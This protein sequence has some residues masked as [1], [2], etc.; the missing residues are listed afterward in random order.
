M[1]IHR[2]AHCTPVSIFGYSML[3][4]LQAVHA[5]EVPKLFNNIALN[6]PGSWDGG[7]VPGT[8]DVAL[9]NDLFVSTVTT[10][11]ALS[12]MGADLSLLGIKVT[13]VGGTRNVATNFVGFQNPS[14]TNT[15]TLGAGG[16]DCSTATQTFY[17]SPKVTIGADQTWNIGNANTNTNPASFNNN[18]DLVFHAQA[19]AT[20]FNLG[21]KTVTTTGAG[22]ITIGSG[23]TVSNGTFAVGNNLLVIAGGSNRVTTLNPDLNLVVNSGILRL[24]S[25]S[26]AGGVSFVSAA[27]VTVNAARLEFLNNNGSFSLAQSGGITLNQGSTLSFIPS[28]GPGSISGPISVLGAT[29]LLTSGAGSPAAAIPFSGNL[30]GSGAINHAN[31]AT[32]TNGHIVLSGDNS[33]YSG[34]LTLN[35][36]SGNRRLLLSTATSGSAAAT[37][38]IGADNV[39]Q[40]NGVSIQLGTLSGGGTVTNSSAAAATTLNVSAGSFSGIISDGATQLT[41]LTKIGTGLLKLSGPNTYSGPTNVTSGQLVVSTS[42]AAVTPADFTVADAAILSVA[43]NEA[44]STLLTHNLTLGSTA[45]STLEISLG[46]HSNPTFPTVAATSLLVNGASK[47]RISGTNLVTGN[48]P[49]VQYESL[50]GASGF[51]GLSLELPARTLG[52]LTNAG[53]ILGVKIDSVEQVKW[54]GNIS[55]DWDIDPD[56]SQTSGTANWKTTVTNI[57]TRYRQ[58][59][60]GTDVVTFDDTASGTGTVN[61]TTTL[62]PAGLTVNN[63]NK[64]YT[65]SGTGKISGSTG[66][67]KSG[68]GTLTLA[69]TT[70]NDYLGTTTVLGGTLRLGDGI[71]AGAGAITG[72]IVNEG[73]LVLDRPDDFTF[74]H[75]LSGVG[76]LEKAGTNTVTFGTFTFANP[77][78]VTGGKALFNNGGTLSGIL[79]GTG[80]LEAAGGTLSIEGSE[81]NTNT[82]LVTVS[83]GALRLNKPAGIAAVGGDVTIRGGGT[84]AIIGNEQIPD[85]ATLNVLGTSADSLVNSVGTETIANANLSGAVPETQLILRNFAVITGTATI[86]QGILGVASANTATVNG[87]VMN[88]ATSILRISGNTA[89]STLNLG[90]GGLTASAGEVQIKF[91]ANDQDAVLNLG[92]DVTTTGNLSFTNGGYGGASLNVINLL[93][94]VHTFS[95]GGATTTTVA[96]DFGGEGS[97][98]KSGTG[99]LSLGASSAAAHT[100]GT[101]VNAGSLIANG[102]LGGATS[103]AA[104]GTIGGSGTLAGSTTVQGTVAPGVTTGKLTTT[105]PITLAGGSNYA[106]DIASWTGTIPGTDWDLLAADTLTLAATPASK[107]TIRIAGS[108]AGFTETAKTLTIATSVNPLTGFDA[109]AIAIDSTGFTGSGT[110][111]VQQT[112]NT[113]E[114]VYSSGSGSPYSNWASLKGLTGANSAPGLDPDLD[115]AANFLE[116]AL[117][118]DP[119]SGK[120]DGKVASKVATVGNEQ[121]LTLTIPVRSIAAFGGATEKTLTVDNLVYRIQGSDTLGSWDLIITEI[122]GADAAAIQQNLPQLDGGWFYHSFRS[123]GPVVGDPSE[124]LRARVDSTN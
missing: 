20:P 98:V 90:S 72:S 104:T 68:T 62:S 110:W 16:I 96:P 102:I 36:A 7:V 45:G 79:S 44:D 18:E 106:F 42:Q 60:G 9:W 64:A 105:A 3:L 74:T 119:L 53:G 115:G 118:G 77:L 38:N 65:F 55:N 8:A 63:T 6:L 11:G 117:N 123:P 28:G 91:N 84:V 10:T 76:G 113:L 59:T 54:V 32:G 121:A 27:P 14:S 99:T 41:G 80:Q 82:G 17:A 48:F 86:T 58:G 87:V 93:T 61:L 51:T 29:T 25:N 103:V 120:S 15:L 47:I 33:G 94:G 19:A 50:G 5:A 107:L 21:G 85:T 22:Q 101:T 56:G 12:T 4:C 108:P 114:L 37:W 40:V 95:I 49:L 30:S 70:P 112:G 83:A 97:L 67:T 81:P 71:T 92:G 52:S 75:A 73:T 31:T 111:A 122:T 46:A 69:N 89:A 78:V 2:T 66:I 109:T 100:G 43:Q 1:K 116:F 39:L 13:A 124:F 35:G 26:G 88:S 24:Q 34:T 57:P 23:Y